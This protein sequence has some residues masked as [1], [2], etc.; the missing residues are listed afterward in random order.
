MV[1]A[2]LIWTK[3]CAFIT[4]HHH[5]LFYHFAH[6]FLHHSKTSLH[7]LLRV[8]R[9]FS[10]LFVHIMQF[11]QWIMTWTLQGKWHHNALQSKTKIRQFRDINTIQILS[12]DANAVL[13]Y[14]SNFD[15]YQPR[16]ITCNTDFA[17]YYF[18]FKVYL[19]KYFFNLTH[20]VRSCKQY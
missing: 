16:V 18:L 9:I 20:L 14:I 11:E 10:S 8:P 13:H 1:F 2:P 19:T 12:L 6:P 17:M 3:A 5:P 4:S 15:Q 7:E